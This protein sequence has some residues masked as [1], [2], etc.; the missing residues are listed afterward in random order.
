MPRWKGFRKR[1][2]SK[3]ARPAKGDKRWQ[4]M[5]LYLVVTLII[6]VL[7]YVSYT[8]FLPQMAAILDGHN[9]QAG[10]AANTTKTLINLTY[11]KG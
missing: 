7:I 9:G 2:A 6:L 3:H 1:K 11:V 5:L 4:T 8:A 10:T